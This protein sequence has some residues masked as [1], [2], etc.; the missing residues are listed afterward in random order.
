MGIRPPG[1]NRY[2]KTWE[3]LSSAEQA[4]IL[5]FSQIIAVDDQSEIPTCPLLKQNSKRPS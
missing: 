2:A 5:A 4:H 1:I 3:D